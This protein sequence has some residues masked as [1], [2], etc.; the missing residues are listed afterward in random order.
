M[1]TVVSQ[2]VLKKILP[3]G[4]VILVHPLRHIPKVSIN[5]WYGVGSKHENSDQKGLAHLI[6]HMIFKGT[7]EKFSESDID[8]TTT[9]LSGYTN[10][11]T[12]YDYTCYVFDFPSS[13]WKHA[14]PLLSDC[15]RNCRFDE[16]MLNSEL[17]AVIQELKMYRDDYFDTLL[18]RM[19]AS[20]FPDHPYH[21]P[22]IGFKQDLWNLQRDALVAFYHKHYVPNNA[23]LVVVGD[24]EAEEVFAE[25]EKAF[26]HIPRDPHYKQQE[27]YHGVDLVGQSVTLY[28]DVQQPQAALTYV[29][30]GAR[31]KNRYLYE[32]AACALGKGK[33]SRLYAKVVDEL[34]LASELHVA[35]DQRQDATLMDIT[36][37]P[38][39]EDDIDMIIEIIQ[40]EIQNVVDKGLS[41]KELKRAQKQVKA[42]LL[43]VL[44]NGSEQA[45]LIGEAY[46]LTGDEQLIFKEIAEELPNPDKQIRDLLEN[47]CSSMM[48]HEG[49]IVSMTDAMKTRWTFLQELS[50][51]EDCRILEGRTRTSVIEPPRYACDIEIPALQKCSFTK[52]HKEKLSNGL[53]VITAVEAV[54]PKIDLVLSL[55]VREY[56]D[57]EDKQGLYRFVCDLL[58]EGTKNYPGALFAEEVEGYGMTLTTEPG[59]IVL[60]VLKEDLVKGLEFLRE[61]V[62]HGEF[63]TKTI[64]KVRAHILSDLAVYWDEPQEFS[65]HILRRVMYEGHPYAKDPH[66]TLES[67]KK[68][69]KKDIESFYK[70]AF[71]PDGATLIVV[72]DIVG[73]DVAKEVAAHLGEWQGTKTKA[74]DFPILNPLIPITVSYPI[75]RDQVVLMFAGRS[76]TRLHEDY[77]KLLLFD[78]IFGGGTNGSMTSQLMK[79]REQ[80][81]LFYGIRGSLIVGCD[82][83]AGMVLVKTTVSLDRLDEAKEVLLNAIATAVDVI[84]LDEF[85]EAKRTIINGLI[86]NMSSS[87]KIAGSLLG[88][89]RLNLSSDYFDTF[90]VKIS[91]ITLDEMKVAAR[92]ILNADAMITIEIGRVE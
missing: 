13:S 16:Q 82:E 24:V 8:A 81:G 71:I 88:L 27:F 12:S 18:S 35:I 55:P 83:E 26:G 56:A 40:Q 1:V 66:G 54:V 37:Q 69:S 14:L 36:F 86:D 4:L 76:I 51:K 32:V 15:M 41:E 43:S 33:S 48:R 7:H 22:V 91:A 42:S 62:M 38:D 75:N 89:E 9:K 92:K 78:Q 67:I 80:T 57:P 70:F 85:E 79:I 65:N 10:A 17:S 59:I 52:S 49:R 5:L 19:A 60:S 45:S 64:E 3:N 25:V 68:I 44:E 46:M 23:V 61:I 87:K 73:Y 74:L 31:D 84:E 28:R 30:P 11:F 72:G 90:P 6:E 21:Y 50:D 53:M 58:L 20:I 34:E 29:L 77:E 39:N 2:P 47:Y 63:D